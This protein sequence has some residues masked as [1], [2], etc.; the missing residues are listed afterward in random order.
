MDALVSTV[1]CTQLQHEKVSSCFVGYARLTPGEKR[2]PP[3]CLLKPFSVSPAEGGPRVP[4]APPAASAS[5]FAPPA[6]APS[7]L[8]V[9]TGSCSDD[10]EAAPDRTVCGSDAD[11]LSGIGMGSW[12][13]ERFQD[14][15]LR[16][17]LFRGKWGEVGRVRVPDLNEGFKGAQEAQDQEQ[18]EGAGHAPGAPA[19]GAGG[20]PAPGGVPVGFGGA[21]GEQ[22]RCALQEAASKGLRGWA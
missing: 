14:W 12:F 18:G 21:H 9:D 6:A 16:L 7:D 10:A 5:S 22:G 17:A 8:A 3:T 20:G 13:W 4:D 1:P 19:Q 11:K 15:V 2:P